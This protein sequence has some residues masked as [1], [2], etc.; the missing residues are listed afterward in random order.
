MEI[1]PVNRPPRYFQYRTF[2]PT[3]LYELLWDLCVVAIV[4]AVQHRRL[5]RPGRLFAVYVTAY[6]FGRFFTE[7]LR[8]DFAHRFLGLRLND[9]TSIVVFVGAAGFVV[10]GR[11]RGA[12]AGAGPAVSGSDGPADTAGE[13]VPAPPDAV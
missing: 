4:L 10:A 5:V 2:H 12:E 6:T 1:D 3:F 8:V 9:W 13:S 7:W 11:R